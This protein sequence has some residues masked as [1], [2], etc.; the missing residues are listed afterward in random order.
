VADKIFR[1]PLYNYISIDKKDDEWL[2]RLL[3]T[4]EMQRL[5]RVHQLGVSHYTFPGAE[6][7]R[8]GHSLGVLHLMQQALDRLKKIGED[9]HIRQAR[10]ALLSGA[11]IHDVGHG[12]FSHVF[13]PCLDVKHE[14]WS[15]K[16]I[17]CG[18]LPIHKVLKSVHRNLPQEVVDLIRE[19]CLDVPRWQKNLLSSQL[20]MDRLDYLRRDSLFTG[21]GYGHFD[22]HRIIHSLEIWGA[23]ERDLVWPD[24][25]KL[26]IEEYIFARFYMYHNVYFH[27]T[28]RGFERILEAMWKHARSALREGRPPELLP[29]ILDFWHANDPT[30]QQYLAIEEHTVLH[31]IH[32][33][34]SSKDKGL[35]DLARRFLDRDRFVVID[36]PE[37]Q[38]DLPQDLEEWEEA[39]KKEVGKHIDFQPAELY[40]LKDKIKGKYYLPYYLPEKEA[41]VQ[42]SRNAIRLL[43]NDVPQ[44]ISTRLERL[45]NIV[46]QPPADQPQ[47][48]PLNKGPSDRFRFYVPKACEQTAKKLR[49]GWKKT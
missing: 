6:H 42:S 13:E 16:I 17:L 30:P 14:D 18:E 2:L 25:S 3:D 49:D 44:E 21:A 8:L 45:K 24:K 28:T 34:K 39:L 47:V 19:D 26:A 40:C 7:T 29:P 20:D 35:A 9:Q 41:D 37:C 33:W 36:P 15:C 22:W 12:P 4:P 23:D 10:A 11:L 38:G 48:D 31:Q 1:D 27:R 32:V 46:T 43:V 5:R